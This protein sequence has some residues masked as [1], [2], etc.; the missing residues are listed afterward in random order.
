M[1]SDVYVYIHIVVVYVIE[2][3]DTLHQ[4][5]HVR[6]LNEAITSVYSAVTLNTNS[7]S[8]SVILRSLVSEIS[9]I[10]LTVSSSNL[11]LNSIY[12]VSLILIVT[13]L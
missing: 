12:L 10:V 7:R 11:I 8:T 13:Q 1:F 3:F 5:M 4:I 2:L 9:S 6:C